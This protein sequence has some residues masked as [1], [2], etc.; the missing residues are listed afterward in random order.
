MHCTQDNISY[1]TTISACEFAAGKGLVSQLL[2]EMRD[3]NV[4]ADLITFNASITL[5]EWLGVICSK[6]SHGHLQY[7]FNMLSD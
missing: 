4:E 1:N 2:A 5:C 6:D 3:A 7:V